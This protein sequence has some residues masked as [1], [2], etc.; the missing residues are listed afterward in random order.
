MKLALFS[1]VHGNLTALEAV[2]ADIARQD[3]DLVVFAG[4]LC[5][6]GPRPAE[7]LRLLRERQI[8]S[9]LGNTD[10]FTVGSGAP[11]PRFSEIIPWTQAELGAEDTAWLGRRPFG[12]RVAPTAR[13]A[14]DL[15]IVHANPRDLNRIVFPSESDQLARYGHIRQPDAEL[16]PLFAGVEA[17]VVAYGHIHVPGLRQ[18]GGTL[19]VNVASVSMPGDGDPRA[20]YA[21]LAWD[22]QRWSAEH[23]R[24][25]YDVTREAAA[26]RDKRTPGWEEALAAIEREGWYYPQKV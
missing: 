8:A 23:R 1:D 20:K 26:F 7:C 22:G 14:D 11:P 15:L 18:S 3:A 17:A 24:V 5:L 16:G 19:L 6:M 2:L 9:I 25:A 21:L 4:D 13:A 10:E 12:L